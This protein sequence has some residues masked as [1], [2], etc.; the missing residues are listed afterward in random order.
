[1][2]RELKAW[3]RP[4]PLRIA[5]LIQDG[6]HAN[7]A[8]DG[9]F[10]DCYGRWG[11]RFSL[12]VPCRN[13]RIEQ[14]Y[15][16][17]LETYDPDIVY[18]Y[19]PLSRAD[20]LEVH[21]R[22]SP[23]RYAYHKVRREP[24]LDAFDF[25]PSYDFP[26]LSSLSA[27]FRLARYS[28]AAGGSVPIRIIDSWHTEKPTRF[29]TD[30]FGTYH[31]SWGSNLYPPDAV[32]VASLLTI[33]SPETQGVPH[34]LNAIPSEMHAFR[35][36]ADQRATSLSLISAR[37]AQQ[38]D[39]RD[40]RWSASFNLV[41]GDS[42]ADRV[43]FWNARLL[44]PAW[45]DRDL[46]CFRV[47]L[48]QLKEP[49][50]LA[51]LGDLLKRRNRVNA[52]SGGPSRITMR[53][54]SLNA[55]QLSEAHQLVASTK[56]W[57]PV[58]TAVV[59]GLDEVVPAARELSAVG[60]SDRFGDMLSQR[61]E[62]TRFIWSPPTARP[63]TILPDHLSDAPVRQSFN[64][65]YWCADFV[66]EHDG[67]GPVFGGENRWMLPRRWRMARAFKVS[68]V[69]D[70]TLAASSP[71]RRS[72]GGNLTIFVSSDHPAETINV[73][74]PYQAMQYAFAADGALAEPDDEHG[75]VYPPS[76]VVWTNPS[77]EA[78]YLTGVLGM[79]N[80]LRRAGQ[81]LLHP[82]LQATFAK[83]GGTPSLKA[84]EVTP[85]LHRLL[86]RARSE[87][88]F[89]LRDEHDRQALANLIVKAAQTLKS[90][91]DFIRY[92]ALKAGWK[93]Y[94]E[95]Y[96][97]AQ[98][99]QGAHERDAEWDSVEEESLDACLM[100][101]RR[102]QMLYQGH[103][104]TC[105]KCHHRNWVDLDALS[106]QLACEV[107]KQPTQAPV[108][109]SWLFRPNEF[110]IESLRDHSVLSLVWA[111][112]ALSM[113]SRRSLIFVEPTQFGFSPESEDPDAEADLL[114]LLD[115]KAILCEV[116]ASWRTLRPTHI[117]DLVALARRLRPDT[118][119]LA[120][121]ESRPPELAADIAVATAQLAAE[122]IEFELLTLSAFKPPDDS[123]L[124]FEHEG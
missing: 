96:W 27:I 109:I 80:G 114:V 82:F 35:E 75:R 92:D 2:P 76:K 97:A 52:G 68:F 31:Q 72:R 19:V 91:M 104:W 14:R 11:G 10:A 111:L 78:R 36:F 33:V 117:V 112:L 17:W 3:V 79:T 58:T 7:L 53:S 71:T 83:L 99:Q 69:G 85:T 70:A 84:R 49:E 66:F 73:P 124:H 86:K 48:N 16:P 28:P 20:V 74:T 107:C 116:K 9:I 1:M 22:L 115:G 47:G 37:L 105:R 40:G 15:W 103:Q 89:D 108:N 101:M 119:L 87:P 24:P 67:P 62:W 32:T 65:G 120:V 30:N 38:L 121:M 59:V 12:I 50:F 90:P 29:L 123:Y 118:A 6:A 95:A 88:A 110:L 98:P 46:C 4:R 122:G 34:D 64:L 54:I 51:V 8:L 81:F 21:E 23:A 94:R 55:D 106:S 93:T 13:E 26:L 43:L 56:P 41:V 42:F 39:I 45:L 60:E 77:N 25:K 63:P 57:G 102:A 113:R 61:P 100:E 44:I 18:S 5:F